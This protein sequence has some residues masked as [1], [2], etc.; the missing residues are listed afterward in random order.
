MNIS[1][2]GLIHNAHALL[3]LIRDKIANYY[4]GRAAFD[5]ILTS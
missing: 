1:H 5:S 4:T 3:A 2:T